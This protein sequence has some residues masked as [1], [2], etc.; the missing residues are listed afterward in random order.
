MG[1]LALVEWKALIAPSSIVA[2][3]KRIGKSS[4]KEVVIPKR[5]RGPMSDLVLD[6]A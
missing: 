3:P 2:S 4:F 5:S 6:E 1:T